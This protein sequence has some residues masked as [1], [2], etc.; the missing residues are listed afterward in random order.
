MMIQIIRRLAAARKR[1]RWLDTSPPHQDENQCGPN[2][3]LGPR[4]AALANFQ[5]TAVQA[6]RI[7]VKR[8]APPW[9]EK[10]D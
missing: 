9:A 8:G 6:D 2:F 7:N 5:A 3:I 4:R 1:E 10:T